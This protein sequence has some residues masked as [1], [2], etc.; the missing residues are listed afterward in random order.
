MLMLDGKPIGWGTQRPTDT[1][2][3]L[4]RF[5]NEETPVTG[6]YDLIVPIIGEIAATEVR[7][8]D[9]KV[10]GTIGHG[11]TRFGRSRS[12]S[13]NGWAKSRPHSRASSR[14]PEPVVL[15]KVCPGDGRAAGTSYAGRPTFSAAVSSAAV[16]R[17][18]EP[19]P[20]EGVHYDPAM[21]RFKIEDVVVVFHQTRVNRALLSMN[22]VR[23]LGYLVF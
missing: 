1:L 13:W 11:V 9:A 5:T 15:R 3:A 19:D 4:R 16:M 2:A 21:A 6:D 22:T 12:S 17:I 8:E 14:T 10:D 7:K 23:S 18:Y 20:L